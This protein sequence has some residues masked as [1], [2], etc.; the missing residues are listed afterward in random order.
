[1]SNIT[2]DQTSPLQ[3]APSLYDDVTSIL[4][5]NP[6]ITW[7]LPSVIIRI[8]NEVNSGIA[9][10]WQ[11]S[12]HVIEHLNQFRS[13]LNDCDVIHHLLFDTKANVQKIH[14]KTWELQNP[15]VK[16]LTTVIDKV[17]VVALDI[18][19]KGLVEF[20]K[21]FEGIAKLNRIDIKE[22][23]PAIAGYLWILKT[24]DV[25][26]STRTLYTSATKAYEIYH[27][28]ILEKDEVAK[29]QK[30]KLLN[31]QLARFTFSAVGLTFK[32]AALYFAIIQLSL[33]AHALYVVSLSAK[34]L[35]ALEVKKKSCHKS[36][37]C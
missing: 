31:L 19:I 2:F 23:F 8:I 27:S 20:K 22:A 14:E 25:V 5:K 15:L 28:E 3:S 37:I 7:E 35:Y 33:I 13:A 10:A 1:M 29:A 11:F 34:F 36:L 26:N 9:P 32:L 21:V 6:D 24:A 17:R 12:G 16:T 30:E 18:L 4:M